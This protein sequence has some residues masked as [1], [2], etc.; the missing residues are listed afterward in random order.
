MPDQAPNI[1]PGKGR[2]VYDKARRTIV[3]AAR[4]DKD[5]AIEFGG[6]LARA[7][8]HYLEV[9]NDPVRNGPDEL[10]D[11]HR[12]LRSSIHEFRKR[13]A[14]AGVPTSTPI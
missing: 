4:D 14:R 6:Y 1:E 7:A 2:L 3:A 8:E 5:Y 12:S 9:V 10:S 13:A 11:A